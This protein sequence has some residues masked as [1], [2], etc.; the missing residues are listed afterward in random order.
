MVHYRDK[1]VHINLSIINGKVYKLGQIGTFVKIEA[2]NITTFGLVDSV[3]NTPSSDNVAEI[4]PGSRYLSISLVG[5]KIGNRNFEKGIGL[6]PTI[7][8]E[9]HLV[10]E[11]DL[12]DLYSGGEKEEGLLAIGKHASSEN[13]DVYLDIHKLVLRHS[14]ILGSTGSGKSNGVV[15][16]I[17]RLMGKMGNSRMV[18][19]D[20]H[21]EYASA[22][23]EAKVFR[24]GDRIGHYMFHSGS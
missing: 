23:P 7:K 2:G 10:T 4:V 21:G 13:L 11:E 1:N 19:I 16:V 3:S 24:I 15:T 9:V 12:R 18:L 6:Y 17:K 20:P 14:A 5:E 22:F 8:D